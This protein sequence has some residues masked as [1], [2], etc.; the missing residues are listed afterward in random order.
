MKLKLK[1]ILLLI[2]F[3]LITGTISFASTNIDISSEAGLL[4]EVSTGKIL[5]EKNAYKK[6]YPASTT[7]ILTAILVIENCNLETDI[8]T[9]SETALSNI[10]SGYVTCN[11]QVG[12]EIS[13]KDLLYALMIP[14]A[15]DAAYVLAEYVGGSVEGFSDMMNK[16][17]EEIGC[18]GTHF[19]NPNGIHNEEH[20]TTAHDLYLMA[21]YAMKNDTFREVVSQTKYT[22]PATNKYPS[23][24]R[25]LTTTNDLLKPNSRNYYYESAIGI[26][27]GHT[28]QAGNCLVAES[29]KD[30]LDF[31][32]VI[33]NG[34][35]TDSGLNARYT[36]SIDLFNYG[37]DNYIFSD[38]VMKNTII[39]SIEVENGSKDTRNLDLVIDTNINA[40]HNKNLDT[41]TITP[42]ISL[43]EEI[44]A[45]ITQGEKLG[46]VKYN[47]EGT[48]YT[49]N[50]LAN[51]NVEKNIN[52]YLILIIIGFVLLFMASRIMRKN[53]K[54]RKI[55]NR[56]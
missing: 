48:E 10:P 20:Y 24:D 31:I 18:T 34:G 54:R 41:S 3:I 17:A 37:Y 44:L 14:S 51:S 26:K 50:L 4:V 2:I 8:A 9:V 39:T 52:I 30:G 53:K 32:S 36:E 7:K 6:M 49:A 55:N 46:T 19:V 56:K 45:P 22:L 29:S 27:T 23:E 42:E 1:L 28:T 5:Y 47:I 38:V 25:V 12:E 21:N 16:K 15:N 43:N 11:L 35:T 13:V 33:L 40:L